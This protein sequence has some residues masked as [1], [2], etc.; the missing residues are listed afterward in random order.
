MREKYVILR[1]RKRFTT[2]KRGAG[3]EEGAAAGLRLE[4]LHGRSLPRFDPGCRSERSTLKAQHTQG[5]QV[6]PG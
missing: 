3:E 1:A 6:G 2:F 5:G 4:T